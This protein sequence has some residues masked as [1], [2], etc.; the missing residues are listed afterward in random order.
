[1]PA[2]LPA[3]PKST[4]SSPSME[5]KWSRRALS[6]LARIAEHIAQ[7]SPVAATALMQAFRQTTEHSRQYPYL[8]RT[9]GPD[10]RELVLHRH[11][12]LT[13]RIRPGKVEILQVWH[14]A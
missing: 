2:T 13:Y 9:A 10:H 4:R 14:T 12:L 8:G 11:Y 3:L 1:M 6:D 5:L 7:E